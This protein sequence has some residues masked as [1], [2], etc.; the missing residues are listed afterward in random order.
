LI[1]LTVGLQEP[2]DR[3]VR[4]VDEWSAQRHHTEIFAQIGNAK[5][6]PKYMRF[7]DFVDP[8]EFKDLVEK[9][10]LI[11]A[12]AGIGSIIS[13]LEAGK[14]IV[15]MPRR[16]RFRE[17]RNDHQV[18]TTK[19]FEAQGRVIAA[20][21][22]QSVANQLDRALTLEISPRISSNASPQLISTV[23]SFLDNGLN[24][25]KFG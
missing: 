2:F 15:V 23:R 8:S 12:H 11:V 22:E 19:H 4:A 20:Y 1:L 24:T 14:P 17:Q 6:V 7:I 3:L 13:A 10:H 21:E 9:A 16:A 18:A 5:Y 25:M